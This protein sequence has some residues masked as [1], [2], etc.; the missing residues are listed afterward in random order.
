MLPPLLR[1]TPAPTQ[2]EVA[3]P[4]AASPIAGGYRHVVGTAWGRRAIRH[5]AVLCEGVN[6]AFSSPI[7]IVRTTLPSLS[8]MVA[9]TLSAGCCSSTPNG[10]V[11]VV[12]PLPSLSRSG[13]WYWNH[14]AMTNQGTGLQ[15]LTVVYLSR[16]RPQ[17]S[18]QL[19]NPTDGTDLRQL[20]G[21]FVVLQGVGRIT[22]FS[23]AT[24]SV[25]KLLCRSAALLPVSELL[26][27]AAFTPVLLGSFILPKLTCAAPLL[28]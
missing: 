19:L 3:A 5:G 4:Q 24:N 28:A 7:S 25:R 22:V 18:I 11:V 8:V 20:G 9:V 14:H 23:C 2:T 1:I 12:A 26:L 27:L 10:V 16:N 17:R 21:E 13:S 15:R 6:P